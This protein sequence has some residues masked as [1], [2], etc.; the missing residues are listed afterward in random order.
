MTEQKNKQVVPTI[1]PENTTNLEGIGVKPED[2]E[3]IKSGENDYTILGKGAFGYAEKM[4]SKLNNKIY[5]VKKLQVKKDVSI[6]FVRETTFMLE[7][8]NENIVK[9]YGYFQGMEK[10]TK[11]KNI[12][13]NHKKRLYQNETQDRKMYF[14]VLDYMSNGSLDDLIKNYRREKKKVDQAFIIKILKQLLSGL[15]YLHGK[16][17]MHRDVKLD[18]ILLDENNNVKISDFGIS[19]IHRDNI[20]ENEEQN[21]ALLSNFTRVGRID[22]VAPEILK[23]IQFDYKVDIFSLGLTILCLMSKNHPIVFDGGHRSIINN[24]IDEGLYD[25]HL[26]N[27]VKRMILEN[28]VLRPS[29]PEAFEEIKEIEEYIQNPTD[30]NERKLDTI[31]PPENTI[32]LVGIGTRPEDFESIKSGD[33]D[34]TILGKGGFGYAEKMRSKLNNKFYAVKRLPVKKDLNK[35]FIRET[36]LMINLSHMNVM[37]LYGYFQGTE[38]IEKLKY[39]YRNDKK[40]L[41][42]NDTEDK[43]MYFLVLDFMSNG[44]LENYYIKNMG[45]I[46]QDFIIKVFK[47]ILSGL[48]Y[49][50]ANNIMHRDIKLDNI[51]LDDNLNAR[52]SDLGIS[53]VYRDQTQV[54][55]EE[56]KLDPLISDF[57][58]VGRPDFTAPEIIYHQKGMKDFDFKVDIYSLGLTILCLVS[59]KK[60]IIKDDTSGRWVP[61]PDFIGKQYNEYLI[62]LVDRMVSYNPIFRPTAAEALEELT[63][64]ELYIKNPN[65]QELKNNLDKKNTYEYYQNNNN[66]NNYNNNNYNNQTNVQSTQ[67]TTNVNNSIYP[68]YPNP[69]NNNNNTNF[70]PGQTQITNQMNNLNINGTNLNMMNNNQNKQMLTNSIN[71]L[72]VQQK[73][74][75]NM[76]P[77]NMNNEYFESNSQTM[78]IPYPMMSMSSR[79]ISLPNEDNNSSFKSIFKIFYYCFSD[80]LMNILNSLQYLSQYNYINPNSFFLYALNMIKEMGNDPINDSQTVYLNNNIRTLRNQLTKLMGNIEVSPFLVFHEVYNRLIDELKGFNNYYQLNIIYIINNL[81]YIPS[82]ERDKFSNVYQK[83]G[84]FKTKQSPITD[85]FYFI[86]IDTIR[87]PSC[88][89]IIK[90]D[91]ETTFSI[92]LD[93]FLSG[94]ISEMIDTYFENNCNSID[95]YTCPYCYVDGKGVKNYLFLTRPRYLLINFTGD[96]NEMEPK[97]LDNSINITQYC[98]PDSQNMGPMK[99][100]LFA[101]VTKNKTNEKYNAF[102]KINNEWYSYNA[103]KMEKS[104]IQTFNDTYPF[105]VVYKG[106]YY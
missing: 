15:T 62:K 58:R 97:N 33:Q 69:Y 39:I 25:K 56:K 104:A 80:I 52:I 51:L 102:I 2:F 21:E 34:F 47:Q 106:E 38:K 78:V 20:D 40:R 41:Y 90:A 32:F 99:Y 61:I 54:E 76:Y 55:E 88:S 1:A 28:P 14:L 92:K 49:I 81:S 37:K 73:G 79:N 19:A 75:N 86:F 26:I 101:F 8:N 64:I 53:A 60:P 70:Y 84:N 44:S 18:N 10:I 72:D 6:D 43:R 82:L 96:E 50:H 100:S 13:K 71:P 45:K 89:K 30:E 31:L 65:N 48:K 66:N 74:P 17:I 11:L 85:Y 4:K 22:F 24:D 29:A 68:N 103:K 16:G 57:T 35:D 9:L 67:F 5:A 95:F 87:C 7:S 12:Y 3:S 42:Q 46:K 83:I 77:P 93:G 94:N 59:S 63:Q 23:G 36:I 98:F 105:I 27:L 91:V